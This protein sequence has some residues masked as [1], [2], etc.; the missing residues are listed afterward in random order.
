MPNQSLTEQQAIALLKHWQ[1]QGNSVVGL[2]RVV[3]EQKQLRIALPDYQEAMPR[4]GS[5]LDRCLACKYF[6]R[7]QYHFFKD[8][9]RH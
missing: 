1:Q 8:A 3:V 4:L 6:A 2:P 9:G 5:F 7:L